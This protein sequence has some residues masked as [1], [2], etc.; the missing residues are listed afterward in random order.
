MIGTLHDKQ[1]THKGA[2]KTPSFYNREIV[3]NQMINEHSKANGEGCIG[4]DRPAIFVG[5]QNHKHKHKGEHSF[6]HNAVGNRNAR[7]QLM[8]TQVA[9]VAGGKGSLIRDEET[10]RG[11]QFKRDVSNLIGP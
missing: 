11:D 2:V 1:E 6:H 4:A 9:L 3:P 8:Q 10:D 5:T 7:S